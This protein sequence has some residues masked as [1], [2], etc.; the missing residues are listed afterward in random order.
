[1]HSWYVIDKGEIENKRQ[2]LNRILTS[3]KL[4]KCSPD[5]FSLSNQFS[6]EKTLILLDISCRNYDFQ[7]RYR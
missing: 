4:R 6:F 3:D 2:I 7:Q 5:N 1:M